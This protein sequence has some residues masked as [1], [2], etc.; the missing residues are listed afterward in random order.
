MYQLVLGHELSHYLTPEY[1]SNRPNADPL[2][3]EMSN[4]PQLELL[5]NW[6]RENMSSNKRFDGIDFAVKY[7]R[8]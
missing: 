5:R 2:T 6:I 1:Q 8:R 7:W 3:L 4:L